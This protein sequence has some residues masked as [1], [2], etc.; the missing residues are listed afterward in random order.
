[1]KKKL[2]QI[3]GEYLQVEFSQIQG[4][5]RSIKANKSLD[6]MKMAYF[7]ICLEEIQEN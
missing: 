2:D 7:E 6:G 3:F 5:V 4:E 1:M